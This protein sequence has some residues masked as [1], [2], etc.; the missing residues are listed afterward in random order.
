MQ[1]NI[2]LIL[3]IILL[4]GVVIAMT[5]V[6]LTKRKQQFTPFQA[7]QNAYAG[8]DAPQSDD[9][10]AVRK[11]PQEAQCPAGDV[12]RVV[13][14]P[15]DV[16]QSIVKDKIISSAQ[17]N[18]RTPNNNNDAVK[19]TKTSQ[20][21][22]SQ[23]GKHLV[24]F[25]SAK[26]NGQFAGYELLQTLLAAGLRFGEGNIFHRH[27]QPNG[28]GAVMC[29]LAAA[30]T[31]GVFDLQNIGTFSVRGMCLFMET[32]G[33]VTIDE[34]RFS[35]MLD[36]AKQLSDSLDASL[37]DAEKRPFTETKLASYQTLIRHSHLS[38]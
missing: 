33:N 27:Q 3:N 38:S 32:S 17:T 26:D 12:D 10:I 14:S 20:Y 30:T 18:M 36:T 31:S 21:R 8:S 37:L 7:E 23:K 25:L 35:I 9:I 19:V 6:M 16:K 13:L 1:A 29:S 4:V 28:Q 5:Y 24:L 11:I 2:S 22:P 15:A 34:E